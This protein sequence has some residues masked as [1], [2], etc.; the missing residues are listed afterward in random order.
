[1]GGGGMAMSAA[2]TVGGRLSRQVYDEVKDR[3]LRGD[4]AGGEPLSVD[5]IRGRFG[6]SKQPVMEALRL[7]AADGLVDIVPQVGSVAAKYSAQDAVDFYRMFARFES[8]IAEVAAVRATSAGLA[9]LRA[10]AAG[11]HTLEESAD[12]EVR[13]Q[14]YRTGNREFHA[15]IHELSASPI[16]VATSRRLWDLSDFLIATAGPRHAMSPVLVHRN[17]EHDAILAALG[18]RDAAA[19]GRAMEDHILGVIDL[20][21]PRADAG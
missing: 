4:Y 15:L 19:A 7:L 17:G 8:V 9:R 18:V 5:E 16:M 21:Q 6:V 13:S 10:V 12:P 1:M 11:M 3:L 2:S 20:L 14:S